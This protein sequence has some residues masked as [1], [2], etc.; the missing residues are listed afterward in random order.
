MPDLVNGPFVGKNVA[1]LLTDE[2]YQALASTLFGT[3]TKLTVPILAVPAW[4]GVMDAFE[5]RI[6]I[7]HITIS[8]DYDP[9]E[10]AEDADDG[11]GS[12]DS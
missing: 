2:E 6:P 10:E 8:D 3:D 5:Y 7:E 9:E 4:N 12:A 1:L 11:D